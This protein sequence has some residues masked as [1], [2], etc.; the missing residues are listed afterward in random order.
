MAHVQN[1]TFRA[2][3]NF[4]VVLFF[5]GNW[6]PASDTK[7]D[8]YTTGWRKSLEFPYSGFCVFQA[9]WECAWLGSMINTSTQHWGW[10]RKFLN[11]PRGG[12]GVYGLT[13]PVDHPCKMQRGPTDSQINTHAGVLT[14]VSR[15]PPLT[16]MEMSHY[17]KVKSM[18]WGSALQLTWFRIQYG[19]S[20]S[21]THLVCFTLVSAAVINTSTKKKLREIVPSVLLVMVYVWEVKAGP[22]AVPHSITSN[23]GTQ[24]KEEWQ[25]PWRKLLPLQ[26]HAWL[27]FLWSP[28]PPEKR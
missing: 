3:R 25:K 12:K 21:V 6:L 18:S 22:L 8:M 24:D 14:E 28:G 5:D 4:L 13:E 7:G 11:K 10:E 17:Y 19:S 23:Q 2:V 9:C 27:V 15:S 26:T 1:L 16:S 20:V